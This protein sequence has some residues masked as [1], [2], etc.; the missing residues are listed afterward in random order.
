ML[1]FIGIGWGA[2]GLRPLARETLW[3]ESLL[4]NWV[5]YWLESVRGASR[6]A[7]P[8][9]FLAVCDRSSTLGRSLNE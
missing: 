8:S 2:R 5:G 9:V 3:R 1:R 4:C 6:R 7:R